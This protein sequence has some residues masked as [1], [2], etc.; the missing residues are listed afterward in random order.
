MTSLPA[1][2]PRQ[3]FIRVVEQRA[4]GLVEFEFAVGEPEL[5][6]EMLLPRAAFED[7]CAAQ[8]VQP[9]WLVPPPLAP[10]D[11]AADHAW[12]WTLHDALRRT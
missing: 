7:F 11:S 12:T 6:V 9:V 4:D 3:K 10:D 5:F 2:D 1:F 8:G